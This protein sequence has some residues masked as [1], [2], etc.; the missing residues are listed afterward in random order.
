M[1]SL[2]SSTTNR[3]DVPLVTT[4]ALRSYRDRTPAFFG[5]TIFPR[6]SLVRASASAIASSRSG[7]PAQRTLDRASR[8]F[9][10]VAEF[11]REQV[12]LAHPV[13]QQLSEQ[14]KLSAQGACF[15]IVASLE[16]NKTTSAPRGPFEH[17]LVF[18]RRHTVICLTPLQERCSRRIQPPAF[19]GIGY[20]SFVDFKGRLAKS[21]RKSGNHRIDLPPPRHV[22]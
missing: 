14:N 3:C 2:R 22:K 7:L 11:V 13:P 6:G 9:V 1:S 8:P 20:A 21:K 12:G 15:A 16:R 5:S 4:T 18:R 17:R 19:S 10:G